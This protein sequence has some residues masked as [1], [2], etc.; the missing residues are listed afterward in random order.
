LEIKICIIN[1]FNLTWDSIPN[2]EIEITREKSHKLIKRGD[3]FRCTKDVISQGGNF[4][5]KKDNIYISDIDGC[6]TN[7]E[8]TTWDSWL[9]PKFIFH[10]EACENPGL[11]PNELI[12]I[13]EGDKFKCI[14]D[15]KKGGIEFSKDNIY[16]FRVTKDRKQ[17]K[18]KLLSGMMLS[19]FQEYFVKV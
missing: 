8:R 16:G 14:K 11:K 19:K 10:F 4:L 2:I 12:K 1:E 17:W 7:E 3:T 9:I 6:I 5:Y 13:N 15:Y 18:I